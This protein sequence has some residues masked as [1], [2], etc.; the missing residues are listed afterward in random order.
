MHYYQKNTCSSAHSDKQINRASAYVSQTEKNCTP[1]VYIRII[2]HK[3]R[4]SGAIG[5]KRW[6]N[7][8]GSE[9]SRV[10]CGIK[11]SPS[12]VFNV[13]HVRARGRTLKAFNE[14]ASSHLRRSTLPGGTGG[15]R[16]ARREKDAPGENVARRRRG[17]ERRTGG[18]SECR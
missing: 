10:A 13:P 12:E 16:R 4:R 15:I 1:R 14:R 11:L 6:R 17:R 2:I 8:I 9:S 7:P 5:R 3:W 18:W